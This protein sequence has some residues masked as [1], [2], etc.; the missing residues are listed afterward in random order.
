MTM[1]KITMNHKGGAGVI[2]LMLVILI[3][4][5]GTAVL[6][7]VDNGSIGKSTSMEAVKITTNDSSSKTDDS[8]DAID[9]SAAEPEPEPEPESLLPTLSDN[10]KEVNAKN[11]ILVFGMIGIGFEIFESML[12]VASAGLIGAA[13]RG[14]LALHVICQI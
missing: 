3:L 1:R 4:A 7:V 13:F 6:V 2:A 11:Y 9:D 5:V 10:Y 8:S 12:L 14:I